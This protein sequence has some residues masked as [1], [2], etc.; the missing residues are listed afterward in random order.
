MTED[1]Q[2]ARKA[3]LIVNLERPALHPP[4][5]GSSVDVVGVISGYTP[6][7]FMFTMEKGAVPGAKHG[8]GVRKTVHHASAVGKS[9][10]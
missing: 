6:D 1:N 5:P 8:S 3:D 10:A 2:Q 7:P 9:K 4:A